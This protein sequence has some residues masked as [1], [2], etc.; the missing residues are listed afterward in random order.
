MPGKWQFQKVASVCF[1]LPLIFDSAADVPIDDDD[2][3]YVTRCTAYPASKQLDSCQEG[4]YVW[5]KQR[6]EAVVNNVIMKVRWPEK[7]ASILQ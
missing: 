6:S 5:F 7:V 1:R 2:V 3:P 4:Q